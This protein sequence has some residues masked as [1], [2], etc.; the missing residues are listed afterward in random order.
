[1]KANI[2]RVISFLCGCFCLLLC[3]AAALRADEVR[4]RIDDALSQLNFFVD[5]TLHEVEGSAHQ[6]A[7]EV[8]FDPDTLSVVSGGWVKIP[9]I[10][11]DTQNAKRDKGMYK[12]FDRDAFPDIRFEAYAFQC[13][14][15]SGEQSKIKC[16]ISG[17]LTI[18]DVMKNITFPVTASREGENFR[19]EGEMLI[20]R[21]DFRLKTP[22][23]F[24]IIRVDQ[25]VTVQFNTLWKLDQ[26]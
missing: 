17:I 19:V 22:S 2:I 8:L 16:E 25:D 11:M 24:G 3:S 26:S 10:E 20:R 21:D 15:S 18:R 23:V 14:E 1:M 12:M 9:V 6:F 13:A 7:G 5:S 4:Y